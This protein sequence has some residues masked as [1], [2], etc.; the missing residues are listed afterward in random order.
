[1]CDSGLSPKPYIT[2]KLLHGGLSAV[3]TYIGAQ[4]IPF[5]INV[6]KMLEGQITAIYNGSAAVLFL[7]A[8]GCCIG[9][10]GILWLVCGIFARK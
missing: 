10:W 7:I 6:S 3:I 1:M 5:D 4:L 9:V 8:L 2:G